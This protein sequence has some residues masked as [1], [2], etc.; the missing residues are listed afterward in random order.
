MV[1]TLLLVTAMLGAVLPALLIDRLFTRR[2]R[3]LLRWL[4]GQPSSPLDELIYAEAEA[5]VPF[6][7]G[8]GLVAV[9]RDGRRVQLAA[10]LRADQITLPVRVGERL[11]IDDIDARHERVTVS[12]FRD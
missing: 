1:P 4:L 3:S 12:L 5:V 7:N 2:L 10:R 6:R 9:D 11:R 8:R